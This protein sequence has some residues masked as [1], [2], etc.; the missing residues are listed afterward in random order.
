MLPELTSLTGL[1]KTAAIPTIIEW[2]TKK[3]QVTISRGVAMN[4]FR[5]GTKQGFGDGGVQATSG[6]Q[7][8]WES[9]AKVEDVYANDNC[10]NVLTKNQN[11]FQHGNFRGD[12]SPLSPLPYAP[13]HFSHVH[14]NFWQ[15][16]N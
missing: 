11:L 5:R 14:A 7:P 3:S 15:A 8:R 13:D 1:P 6:V 9:G 4:L 12:M 10:N 16:Y 2:S